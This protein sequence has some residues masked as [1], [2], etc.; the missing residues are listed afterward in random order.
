MEDEDGAFIVLIF[1]GILFFLAL[2][3][4]VCKSYECVIGYNETICDLCV[5][6]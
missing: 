2:Q 4:I 3:L 6:I 5:F 1:I